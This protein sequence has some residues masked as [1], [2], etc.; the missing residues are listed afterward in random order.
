MTGEQKLNV[1]VSELEK[2]NFD[3][4][5]LYSDADK[6]KIKV[7]TVDETRIHLFLGRVHAVYFDLTNIDLYSSLET[8]L[9][10]ISFEFE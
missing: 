10:Y 3:V 4:E 8:D 1:I 7:D 2:E 6:A 9:P 5:V